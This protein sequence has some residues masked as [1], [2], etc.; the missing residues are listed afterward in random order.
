MTTEELRLDESEL[1]REETFTDLKVGSIRRLS[2]VTA[3]GK[4]DT[5]RPILFVGQTQLLTQVGPLPV[6]AR[7]EAR[8]LEE[9]IAKFPAAIEEAVAAMMDEL[10]D[11]QRREA[12]RIVVPGADTASKI[13]G[14]PQ[15]PTQK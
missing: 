7:I 12:S 8:T 11:M 13:L 1:Y 6:Q 10:R 4:P 5:G 3:D 14:G 2:P 9:A 15:G